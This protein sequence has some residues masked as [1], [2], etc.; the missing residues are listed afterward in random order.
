MKCVESHKYATTCRYN[1]GGLCVL[2][3]PHIESSELGTYFNCNSREVINN[4]SK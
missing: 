1:A 3:N 2:D 4:E